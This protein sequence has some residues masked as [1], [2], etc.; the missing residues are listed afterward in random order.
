MSN[1][2]IRIRTLV[3]AAPLLAWGFSMGVATTPAYAD[4]CITAPNAPTPKGSHWFYHTD[5]VKKRKCWFLRK[6]DQPAEQA[7]THAASASAPAEKPAHAPAHK[8]A[9]THAAAAPLPL[10]KPAATAGA[11][12]DEP[13]LQS[14]QQLKTVPSTPPASASPTPASTASAAAPAAPPAAAASVWPDPPTPPAAAPAAAPPKA[15]LIPSDVHAAPAASTEPAA[16]A[17]PRRAAK[18]A[19]R[20][21]ASTTEI[22]KASVGGAPAPMSM[23]LVAL[24]ALVA[25]AALYHLAR[26]LVAMRRSRVRL[27]RANGDWADDRGPPPWRTLAQADERAKARSGFIDDAQL[28]IVPD[29]GDPAVRRPLRSLGERQ[30]RMSS[31]VLRNAAERHETSRDEVARARPAR[32][33]DLP[34]ETARPAASPD[35]PRGNVVRAAR[36]AAATPEHDSTWEQLVREL[37]ELLQT[38]KQA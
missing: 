34:R 5:R 33:D 21:N 11:A 20:G 22:N 1:K 15:D 37:D 7:G 30:A 19:A 24:L 6:L 38:K 13:A 3:L 35:T 29:A 17:A 26:K 32:P 25:A 31:S 9:S 4:D 8:S 10:H 36:P 12:P 23:V 28:S 18:S 14:V 2:I 27:E 16:V